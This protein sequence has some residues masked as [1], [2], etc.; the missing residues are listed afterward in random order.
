VNRIAR[1][2]E[3]IEGR[4]NVDPLIWVDADKIKLGWS[5]VR[6]LVNLNLRVAAFPKSDTGE[7]KVEEIKDDG[8]TMSAECNGF[9]IGEIVYLRSGGP[10]MTVAADGVKNI[11]PCEWFS[12]GLSFSRKFAPGMLLR[13]SELMDDEVPG[14]ET[15]I[16]FV[17]SGHA[18]TQINDEDDKE[19]DEER[20]EVEFIVVGDVVTLR[21][22]SCDMTVLN[23]D[24]NG[25]AVC[26]W[27]GARG[28]FEYATFPPTALTFAVSEVDQ[29]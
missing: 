25:D 11:V 28:D 18:T 19:E 2:A 10:A 12:N 3:S 6:D 22:G 7:K 13:A 16:E 24:E 20:E 15:S 8:A 29:E 27:Q 14:A 1:I 23:F 21:S 26:S 9:Q 5:I 17:G 4:H